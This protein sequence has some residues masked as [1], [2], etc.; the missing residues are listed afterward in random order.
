MADLN[1]WETDTSADTFV[2]KLSTLPDA[3]R[4]FFQVV[5]PNNPKKGLVHGITGANLKA[6]LTKTFVGTR[7]QIFT[8]IT[9]TPANNVHSV[10]T[11]DITPSAANRLIRVRGVLLAAPISASPNNRRV[12][13]FCRVKKGTG[14]YTA[15]DGGTHPRLTYLGHSSDQNNYQDWG[16]T[17]ISFEFLLTSV[18]TDTLRF[19][20]MCKQFQG[21]SQDNTSNLYINRAVNST[22]ATKGCTW[23]EATEYKAAPT[24]LPIGITTVTTL[25][26]P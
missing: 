6:V 20:V 25:D 19:N 9:S 21:N 4:I 26:T 2:E 24:D 5:D 8:D 12:V 18:D 3:A 16:N 22:Y 23:I 17:E 13:A 11:V 7:R 1:L 14:S 10:L 15:M